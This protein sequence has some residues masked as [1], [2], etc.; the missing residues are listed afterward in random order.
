M[1]AIVCSLCRGAKPPL[2]RPG[3]AEEGFSLVEFMLSSLVLLV[4]AA[5]AFGVLIQTERTADTQKEVQGVLDNA[6]IAMETI[7]RIIHQ[8][9]NDPK[10]SG[11]KGI[12]IPSSSEIRVR[13]DF[14][15]SA[16]PGSPDQGDPDGDAADTGEDVTIRYNSN[17]R[18]IELVT[19]N[20]TQSIAGNVSAFAMQYYD[21][22]SVVT[23]D[24]DLVTRVRVTFTVTS[25]FPDPQT[26]RTF[27]EQLTADIHVATRQ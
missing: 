8:A 1:T 6:R 11:F 2:S 14:T 24:C 23:A 22:S 16:A 13:T 3:V 12:L 18:T 7:T 17:E 4:I 20:L 10:Q 19:G 26:G 5:S 25:P 27:S 9:G 21:R 15:G